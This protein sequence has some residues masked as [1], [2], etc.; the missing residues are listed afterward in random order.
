MAQQICP[1]KY[2]HNKPHQYIEVALV[3]ILSFYKPQQTVNLNI[4]NFL[5]LLKRR[6]NLTGLCKLLYHIYDA[7]IRD[8]DVNWGGIKKSLSSS[9]FKILLLF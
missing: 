2:F 1:L 9:C 4:E 6:D 5:H 3:S 8:M 7:K